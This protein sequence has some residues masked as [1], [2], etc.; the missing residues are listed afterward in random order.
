MDHLSLYALSIEEGTP[1]ARWN[2]KGL[3]ESVDEELSTSM[4]LTAAEILQPAGFTQ[5][6]ISNWA[7]HRADGKESRCRH[8]LNTWRYQPYF[9]FGAGA[10]G[11]IGKTR[12]AN[13]EPIPDYLARMKSPNGLWPAAEAVETLDDWAEMQEWMMVGLRLT[14][15]GVSQRAFAE[16]FGQEIHSVFRKQFA[17]CIQN[18]LLEVCVEGQDR[19]RLTPRGR[20]L[21]NQVFMEFVG[22]KRPKELS[23]D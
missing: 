18:G 1:L 16:R 6:E 20:L 4:Y 13:V 12:T 7:R 10:H 22:N 15:E 17:R 2:Q 11:F 8:N 23:G 3:L 19:I 14:A 5:Y 21:G 9:G